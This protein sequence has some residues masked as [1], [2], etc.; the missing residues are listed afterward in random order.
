MSTLGQPGV[1]AVIERIE[2][3]E[4]SPHSPRLVFTSSDYLGTKAEAYLRA[5]DRASSLAVTRTME[6][7]AG[8]IGDPNMEGWTL[9]ARVVWALLEARYDDALDAMQEVMRRIGVRVP[10]MANTVAV[11]GMQLAYERGES[12]NVIPGLRMVAD[13]TPDLPGMRGALAVHLCEAGLLDDARAELKILMDTLPKMAHTVPFACVAALMAN[14]AAQTESAE[15]AAA[16]IRE[17][18]P[19]SGEIIGLSANV[20]VGAADHY[21]APLRALLGDREGAIADLKAAIALEDLV[22]GEAWLV[23]SRALLQ[24]LTSS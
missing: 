19:F 24:Q 20:M 16:L 17:L 11:G 6:A 13:A 22:G 5:G 15:Y 7:I 10:N 23:R 18:E 4:G 1:R 21:I 3:V 9:S 2:A 8:T 12:A 14:A